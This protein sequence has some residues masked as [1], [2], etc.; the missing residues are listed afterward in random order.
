ML[1]EHSH[2]L[3]VQNIVVSKH[4]RQLGPQSYQC[5]VY[6]DHWQEMVA[7]AAREN[8]YA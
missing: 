6:E 3:G 2:V 8:Q 7:E 4:H 5:Q 1:F